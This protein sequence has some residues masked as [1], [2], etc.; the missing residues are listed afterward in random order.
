MIY[1]VEVEEFALLRPMH[2]AVRSW[3]AAEVCTVTVEHD[4]FRGRGEGAPIFYRGETIESVHAQLESVREVV[5]RGL[6]REDLADLLPAGGARCA[7]DC[8]LWDLE[9]RSTGRPVH[10]LAGLAE[11]AILDSAV[12]VPLGRPDEMASTASALADYPLLKV[13][14]GGDEDEAAIRAVRAA[15]P[16]ARLTV[17]ANTGWTLERL[18]AMGPVL[19]EV[20]VELV[21]QPL[22]VTADDELEGLDIGVPVAADESCQTAADVPGLVGRFDVGVIKL[23]KAGGLTG[24]IAL[25]R[26]L[27]GHGLGC[28]VSCM[29]STS[30]G[31]AP[32]RLIGT[33]C[34]IVD[35]D[36]PM[37]AREDRVPPI[38]YERGRMQPTPADLWGG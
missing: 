35:L 7:L 6:R 36:G 38:R 16:G 25:L 26:A 3:H 12:T 2:I 15:A 14:L 31:M 27:E 13:K 4:G 23:D 10:E 21:E 37:N 32:A 34:S 1:T 9:A 30:L 18:V 17:D 19:A 28:M 33:H 8:A 11:P 22:P 20:G 24:A 5:E 29:I